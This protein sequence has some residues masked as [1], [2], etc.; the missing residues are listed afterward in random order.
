MIV[1]ALTAKSISDNCMRL[2]QHWLATSKTFVCF[3]LAITMYCRSVRVSRPV[4]TLPLIPLLLALLLLIPPPP[5]PPPPMPLL[6]PP[7]MGVAPCAA[8]PA[9]APPPVAPPT[10][11][12]APP[13]VAP[14]PP[15]PAP[16]AD[17]PPAE[18]PAT[19][20]FDIV[21]AVVG[22]K[23]GLVRLLLFVG[24]PFQLKNKKKYE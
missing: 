10:T 16:P 15:A 7:P 21:L 19:E 5:P 1:S 22:V 6:L 8:P 9:D 2:M 13:P 23:V 18:P 24:V 11:P 3:S 20:V 14:A 12:L 17:A 4:L